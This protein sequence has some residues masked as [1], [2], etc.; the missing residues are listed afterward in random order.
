M[1]EVHEGTFGTHI[2]GQVMAR[3][4]MRAGYFWSTMEKD[5]I[6]Y[7]RKC[8][9]CKEGDLVL[10]KLLPAQKDK[11][12]KWRPN[13]EGPYVVKRAFSGGALILSNMD[14]EEL[15]YPVNSDAVK[16]FYA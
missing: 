5:C 10:R 8:H 11:I 9:K 1:K 2:A 14:G 15:A 6:S 3:K 4:I 13:Y 7:A 16:K 12:G